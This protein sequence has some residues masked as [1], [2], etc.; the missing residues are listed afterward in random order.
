MAL[1]TVQRSPS[2]GSSPPSSVSQSINFF[3]FVV[4]C[5]SGQ[6]TFVICECVRDG[7]IVIRARVKKTRM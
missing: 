4:I 5:L 7:T 3:L 2:V 6:H 1:V